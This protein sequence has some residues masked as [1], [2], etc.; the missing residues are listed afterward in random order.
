[1]LPAP[2]RSLTVIAL[3]ISGFAAGPGCVGQVL[4]GGGEGATPEPPGR[5]TPPDARRPG[6]PPAPPRAD[7]APADPPDAGVVGS[8]D[9]APDDG[10]PPLEECATPSIDRIQQWL[11]SGE[12]LTVPATGSMLVRDGQKN[13]ARIEFV[14][15]EWHVAVV[16]IG[17]QF[18]AQFDLTASRGFT[19]TYAATDDLW[20]QMRPGAHWSGGD[21]Y[22]QRIPSTG[23][24]VVTRTFSFA[25]SAWTTLPE[26]GAPGY[27]YAEALRDVR[28]L[29][30]V[31]ETPNVIEIRGLRI[32]GFTPP[33]R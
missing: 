29:V 12:G 3:V 23:G 31:G 5:G 7:A 18:E 9:A 4:D 28:G 20:V 16:W 11:A 10:L 8:A 21:K 26:L 2:L 6:D 33:C 15:E 14:G 27:P 32:D 17:N 25:A 1:V 19:L 30:F 24:Q 13:V 22:V